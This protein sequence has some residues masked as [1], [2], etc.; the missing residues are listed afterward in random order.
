MT[1]ELTKDIV[2]ACVAD[3]TDDCRRERSCP[4]CTSSDVHKQSVKTDHNA[5][6]RVTVSFECIECEKAWREVYGVVT[7]EPV[8]E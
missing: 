3:L 8:S 7:I 5:I 6:G 1:A 2:D 4:F